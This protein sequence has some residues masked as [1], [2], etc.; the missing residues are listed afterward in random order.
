MEG[1]EGVEGREEDGG[2][3]EGVKGV[4]EGVGDYFLV[5]CSMRVCIQGEI[6]TPKV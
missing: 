4:E 2:E 6:L 3:K 1:R 5:G